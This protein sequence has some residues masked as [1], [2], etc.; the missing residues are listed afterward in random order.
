MP[1]FILDCA[2]N[3]SRLTNPAGLVSAMHD[4]ADESGLFDVGDTKVRCN[5]YNAYTVGGTSDDFVHV[6]GYL[7]SGRSDEQKRQLA[8]R[9]VRRLMALLPTVDTLSI[10]LRD[11]ERMG[12]ANRRSCLAA[13]EQGSAHVLSR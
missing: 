1:H 11:I 8:Q 3:I 13:E 7:L 6:I 4:A 2:Q 12:Y 10:D 9:M 5:F